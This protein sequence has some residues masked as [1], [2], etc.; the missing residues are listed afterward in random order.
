[1][2]KVRKKY[3]AHENKRKSAQAVLKNLVIGFT[4]NNDRLKLIN[5][6]TKKIEQAGPNI[7]AAMTKIRYKWL[8]YIAAMGRTELGKAYIKLEEVEM[9]HPVFKNDISDQVA[10]IHQSL[11]DTVPAKQH[12]NIGWIASPVGAELSENELGELFELMNCWECLAPWQDEILNGDK[13]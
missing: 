10:K 9:P 12:S 8:I 4:A 13:A 7:D 6:K 3:V 2:T 1:M 5:I 11:C